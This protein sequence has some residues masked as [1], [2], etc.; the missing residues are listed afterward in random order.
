MPGVGP[1]MGLPPQSARKQLCVPNEDALRRNMEKIIASALVHKELLDQNV[2]NHDVADKAKVRAT[3][4]DAPV[5]ATNPAHYRQGSGVECIDVVRHLPFSQGNAMKYVWRAGHKDDIK[6]DLDKALWYVYDCIA[7]NA[8]VALHEDPKNL[9]DKHLT[10]LLDQE[11]DDRERALYFLSQGYFK[12]AAVAI[13][14][15]LNSL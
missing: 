3:Y 13:K 9:L 5:S 12:I 7:Q 4:A 6:Q 15:W 2:G 14:T 8:G 1:S 11:D 10:Y